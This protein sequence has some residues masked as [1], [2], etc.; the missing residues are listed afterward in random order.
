M[1][2]FCRECLSSEREG[3]PRNAGVLAER[4]ATH[5]VEVQERLR[6]A[7]LERVA[8]EARAREEQAR[9]V[10]EQ[11]RTEEA[12]ARVQAE[13]RARRR[14]LALAAVVLL[15][16]MGGGAGLWWQQYQREQADKTVSNA[17]AQ[18]ELLA[19]QARADP[20]QTDKYHQALELARGAVQLAQTASAESRQKAE[21]LSD[22]LQQEEEAARKDRDLRSALLELRGPREG[23]KYQSDAKGLMMAL[24]E[25]TADEQFAAAFRRW[26]L[27]VDKADPSEAAALLQARPPAAV[28]ELI[29]ALDEWASERRRQD[30]SKK[31]WQRLAKL[32]EIL[33]DDPGSKRRELREILARGRLPQERTL[34][35]LSAMLRPVPVPVEVPL[36][37]DRARLRQLA[38]QTDA[39]GEPILGLLT[40]VR[41]LCVAGEE[42]RAEQLLRA[43]IVARPREVVLY[44]TL[45]QLLTEQKPPR[46][47]EAVECYAVAQAL[48]PDLGVSLSEA[49]QNS[50]RA[51]EGLALLARMVQERPNNPYLHNQYGSA[52]LFQ[53]KFA[54]AEA[55][56]RHTIALEPDDVEAYRSLGLALLQKDKHVE[57]LDVF[58]TAIAHKPDDA[59]LHAL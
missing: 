7:E 48:R 22:R 15:L 31:A 37:P 41:A 30:K 29:A 34:D 13:R 54:E 5:Q 33:D 36:G 52:L 19:E 57:A 38:E 10:V 24:A 55:T 27:D 39:A 47:T 35:V 25:P 46:W 32:A 20:L 9:A 51:E 53:A 56:F 26:G 28:L 17:L 42:P 21:D 6:Q 11:E 23:P 2:A 12:L 43:G 3:R 18:A 8:A 44:H 1:I 14:T 16:L 50:G 40:L 4:V 58:R 49:L 45:G 59:Q